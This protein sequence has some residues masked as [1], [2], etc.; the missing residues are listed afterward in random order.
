MRCRICEREP[1]VLEA[2][3]RSVQRLRAVQAQVE[4]P[5]RRNHQP[6]EQQHDSWADED[7]DRQ[8]A[9]EPAGCTAG[10]EED[11]QQRG[12]EYDD[13]RDDLAELAY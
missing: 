5:E 4:G 1:V 10:E 13:C 11:E 7:R 9:L 3:V 8:R 2:D 6:D 12:E